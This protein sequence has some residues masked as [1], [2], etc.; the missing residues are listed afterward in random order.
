M[1]VVHRPKNNLQQHLAWFIAERP[2]V[3]QQ[4]VSREYHQTLG[5]LTVIRD[6]GDTGVGVFRD[7]LEMSTP[8]L[9]RSSVFEAPRRLELKTKMIGDVQISS[10][11]PTAPLVSTQ[12][13]SP[14]LDTR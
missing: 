10:S 2:Q 3:P 4:P 6:A 1:T 14:P 7:V 5:D 12:I 9:M 11:G 13:V 8:T